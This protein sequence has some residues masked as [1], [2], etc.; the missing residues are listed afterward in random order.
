M[1]PVKLF[2][3]ILQVF[4]TWPC[5]TF[6]SIPIIFKPLINL[7]SQVILNKKET[8]DCA[9]SESSQNKLIH[10]KFVLW[11]LSAFIA[12][13]PWPGLRNALNY[14]PC[15]FLVAQ[16][17]DKFDKRSNNNQGT[18]KI[19]A[20]NF[21]LTVKQN[22]ATLYILRAWVKLSNSK[23]DITFSLELFRRLSFEN[24]KLTAY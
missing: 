15:F 24:A 22:S 11:C 20:I 9:R 4:F 12:Y 1:N 19:K 21:K 5:T 6:S 14:S 7:F 3:M 23:S 16:W 18:D 10:F 13:P 8:R 2:Y 17:F